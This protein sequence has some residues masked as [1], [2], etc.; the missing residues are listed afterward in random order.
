MGKY[1]KFTTPARLGTIAAAVCLALGTGVV[2]AQSNATG[3]VFGTVQTS[4]GTTVLLEN[5]ATGFKRVLTPDASGRVQA[6]SLPVGTYKASVMRDGKVIQSL[7][8]IEV[9]I[10]QGSEM[11]FGTA[12]ETVTVT[13]TRKTLDVSNADS[14]AIFT[15]KQLAALPTARNLGAIVQLAPNTTNVDSRYNGGAS[16]AGGAASE[17]AYYVNGFPITNPLNQLGSSELPFGAIDQAQILNGGFGAEFG[18]SIGGVINVITKSGTNKWEAGAQYSMSPAQFREKA[19]D[20]YFPNT[21]KYPATDGKLRLRRS[22]DNRQEVIY[23]GYVGGPIIKD[24][25]FF[26]FSGEQR[27]VKASAVNLTAQTQAATLAKTGWRDDEA[28]TTRYLGKLDFNI[29]DGHRVDL[30]LIGDKPEL[31]RS[32]SGFNYANN[33]RN[34]VV[35]LKTHHEND[36]GGLTSQGSNVQIL[37]YVGEITDRLT[38]TAVIGKSKAERL[39]TVSGTDITVPTISYAP[40][41]ALARAPGLTYNEVNTYTGSVHRPGNQDK[42]DGKRF[43]LEYRL[44]KHT[45]RLGFDDNKLSTLNGGFETAPGGRTIQYIKA[46]ANQINDPKFLPQGAGNAFLIGAPANGALAAGGYY[47]SETIVTSISNA[48]SDQNAQYIEDRW[49]VTKNL[50]LTGGVRRESYKNRNS[51]GQTFLEVNNQINPRMSAVWDANGDASMKVFGSAGRYSIQIPTL[52]ALRGANG[53]VFTTQFFTYTGVDAKGMPT[54]RI[55]QTKPFSSNAEYGQPK[56]ARSVAANDIK[57]AYQDEFIVG[58]EKSLTRDLNVGSKLTYRKLKATIDDMCDWRPFDAWAKKHPEVDSKA[59]KDALADGHALFSCASFNP[60]TANSFNINYNNDGKTFTRVDL[61]AAE[62]GFVKPTRT[63]IALDFFAEHPFRNGWYGKVNYTYSKNKGNTEGQTNSDLGQ[64]DVSATVTWDHPELSDYGTGYLPNDR[65][66][67]IKAFG[68]AQLSPEWQVAA[69]L[70]LASGRPKNCLGLYAGPKKDDED[71][72]NVRYSDVYY[73]CNGQPSPRASAGSLPWNRRLDLSVTYKPP[74]VKGLD[75]TAE[76]FN[77]TNDQA[78]TTISERSQLASGAPRTDY[79]RV[80]STATP[81]S[82]RFGATYN[83]QF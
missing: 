56:D 2:H 19:P 50:L 53:S 38:F 9:R 57:P 28:T 65:R 7:N 59:W 72:N 44:D 60:G 34:G 46:E 10:A 63:Y 75:L 17:N 68:Y 51:E 69:S 49:Q 76:I 23:G 37:R 33:D 29:A 16:I 80:L 39:D 24:K 40:S 30:T 35:T 27:K 73:Y 67:Q 13:G 70:L 48:Y 1:S 4:A 64:Q 15:A 47:G 36:E 26:F 41:G 58:I 22:E 3:S 8:N 81:R 83:H 71:F 42:V 5:P 62:L 25:L 14:G 52:V 12:L 66:H 79:G 21:G 61:T 82:F 6:T 18:R 43:D 32:L 54:G 77:V 20:I 45:V 55:D 74:F 31:D 11:V 78:V